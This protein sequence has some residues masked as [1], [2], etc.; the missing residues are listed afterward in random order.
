MSDQT[1]KMLNQVHPIERVDE[2]LVVERVFSEDKGL[3]SIGL[4][5]IQ[6]QVPKIEANKEKIL[7]ACQIFKKR[8]ANAAIFILGWFGNLGPFWIKI[9]P[10]F[11]F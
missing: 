1:P 4:A 3:P 7:R 6:A 8:G 2:F 11:I 9:D 5:N 10:S